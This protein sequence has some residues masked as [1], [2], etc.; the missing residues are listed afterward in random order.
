MEYMFPKVHLFFNRDAIVNNI[1]FQIL[2]YLFG[3]KSKQA[4]PNFNDSSL[5]QINVAFHLQSNLID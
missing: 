4:L 2:P 5:A 1:F 3:P